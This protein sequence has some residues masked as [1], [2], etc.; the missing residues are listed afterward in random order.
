MVSVCLWGMHLPLPTCGSKEKTS[1][2]VLFFHHL[3]F[4]SQTQIPGRS[5]RYLLSHVTLWL[6]VAQTRNNHTETL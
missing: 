5:N 3:G 1:V 6:P 2:S 4:R